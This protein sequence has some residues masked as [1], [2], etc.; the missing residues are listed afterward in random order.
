[1]SEQQTMLDEFNQVEATNINLAE[2]DTLIKHYRNVQEDYDT[3][4]EIKKEAGKE[5]DK[6]KEKVIALL[7]RGKKKKWNV[8][9]LGTVTV[10]DKFMV[11]TPKST[12]QKEA[13][14]NWL[15]ERGNDMYYAYASV[16]SQSL[17]SLYNK[18]VADAAE[19]GETFQMPGINPPTSRPQLRWK[20]G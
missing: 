14:L 4:N 18:E 19:R 3:K 17:N 2:V 11:Q 8:D 13:L 9:G 10:V 20:K 1:M 6:A 12:E 16:N 15:K 5:L 7:Q